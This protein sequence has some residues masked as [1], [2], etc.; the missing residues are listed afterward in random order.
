MNEA[1][2]AVLWDKDGTLVDSADLHYETWRGATRSVLG[3]DMSREQF[4]DLFGA[5]NVEILRILTGELPSDDLLARVDAAKEGTFREQARRHLKMMDGALELIEALTAD[6]WRLAIATSAPCENMQL[7]LS[8]FGL[9]NRFQA[10]ACRD[11]V[12]RGKP[13][14][15]LFLLAAERLGVDAGRCVVIEDSIAGVEAARAAGMACIG[16]TSTHAASKLHAATRVIHS[17]RE[18]RPLDFDRL[19]G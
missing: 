19:I 1:A 12:A 4:D 10:T 17:L 15:A 14:P 3:F 9:H 5:D 2:R 13:D 6:G 7:T 8:I 16:L 18:L 11:E